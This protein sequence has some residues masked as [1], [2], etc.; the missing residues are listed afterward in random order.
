MD[1]NAFV[2]HLRVLIRARTPVL[3]LN[4]VD[5]D[6]ALGLVR[7]AASGRALWTWRS[8]HGLEP[9]GSATSESSPGPE[10][11]GLSE[12]LEIIGQRASQSP[13]IYVLLDPGEELFEACTVRQVRDLAQQLAGHTRG[14]LII[15]EDDPLRPSA[16]DR[17]VALVDVPPAGPEEYGERLDS[18]LSGFKKQ[19]GDAVDLDDEACA[20]LCSAACGLTSLEFENL[21]ARRL[22]ESGSLSA[23]DVMAVLE[24]RAR[25]MARLPLVRAAVS[26]VT[27]GAVGGHGAVLSYIRGLADGGQQDQSV[28]S[29]EPRGMLLVGLP[30]SGKGHLVRALA[31][32]LMRPLARIDAAEIGIASPDAVRDTFARLRRVGPVVVW[33][34]NLELVASAEDA[35]ERAVANLVGR[36]L[37]LP[38]SGV[39]YAATAA[40]PSGLHG[41]FLRG[42]A[43]DRTFFIDLPGPSD[44]S[45][46]VKTLLRAARVR[47]PGIDHARVAEA[48]RGFDTAEI[49]R[50]LDEALAQSPEPGETTTE[51]VE[52]IAGATAP[53]AK[54]ADK[55][56]SELR[57][58]ARRHAEPASPEPSDVN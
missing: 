18:M 57:A 30:G 34:E 49:A 40:A 11:G 27:P 51:Q 28:G 16:L 1:A 36:L 17:Y 8:T 56:L 58:W 44:R 33:I 7:R 45:D 42:P 14:T 54:L 38:H 32:A 26:T 13:E 47:V 52:E 20:A 29:A 22:V 50:V 19:R 2:E 41:G 35:A 46:I 24:A 5:Q 15:L 23:D 48:T 37:R 3:H 10:S 53:A 55:E 6:R 21:I 25:L 31:G 39:V 9:D 43:F 4:A 12:A